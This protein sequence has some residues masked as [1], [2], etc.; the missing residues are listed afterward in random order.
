MTW[1]ALRWVWPCIAAD[2]AV[3]HAKLAKVFVFSYI[4]SIGKAV[5]VDP[6]KPMLKAPKTKRFD[7]KIW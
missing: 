5:Q 3:L 4:W 6:M 1:Q 2:A 7:T